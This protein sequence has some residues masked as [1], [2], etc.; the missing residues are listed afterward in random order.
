M[1]LPEVSVNDYDEGTREEI[2]K[3]KKSEG[4]YWKIGSF[5]PGSYDSFG[6][7]KPQFENST[8]RLAFLEW[9]DENGITEEEYIKRATKGA[10]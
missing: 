5:L 6:R 1:V 9:L 8:Q 2:D 4:K 10:L 7:V 3:I